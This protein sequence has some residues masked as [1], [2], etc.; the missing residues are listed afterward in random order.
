M[1]SKIRNFK[2]TDP[3][4]Q[5]ILIMV[6]IIFML[7]SWPHKVIYFVWLA[8]QFVSVFVHRGFKKAT[9]LKEQRNIFLGVAIGYVLVHIVVS[10]FVPEMQFED[11]IA[12]GHISVP[13]YS[14]LLLAVGLAI[15]F[16]YYVICIREIRRILNKN[17]HLEF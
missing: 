4:I 14:N 11:N 12:S 8:W 6:F 2:I 7:Y 5:S 9:M 17:H 3:L 13:I 1:K 16:W 10:L 15:S